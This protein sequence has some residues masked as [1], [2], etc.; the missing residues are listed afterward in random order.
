[1]VDKK[2]LYN[3][4]NEY[5]ELQK[6]EKSIK[7][8]KDQLKA[9]ITASMQELGEQFVESDTGVSATLT[10]KETIKYTD[11]FAVIKYLKNNNLD[12]YITTGIDTKF[13]SKL[14]ESI[15]LSEALADSFTITAIN[16]LTVKNS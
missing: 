1:M 12:E 4:I 9:K 3:Y 5:N 13:N 7:N 10:F 2:E 16:A 6:Q 11:E 14:K 8:R 15:S